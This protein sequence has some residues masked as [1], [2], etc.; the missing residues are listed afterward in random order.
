MDM[1]VIFPGGQ[2]VNALYKGFVIG[3]DQPIPNGGADSAPAPFDL[4]L[5]SIGT[6]A[7]FYVLSFCQRRGIPVDDMRLTLHAKEN[8]GTELIGS[9]EIE[10]QLPPEFPE[11]YRE[12]VRR[13]ATSCAV[14]KHIQ[15][16][17]TFE[18]YTR[19]K[20]GTKVAA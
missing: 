17:P 9:I 16:P 15:N 4:F 7:G 10:I 18:V 8:E 1:E 20:E 14:T 12:A 2:T 11:R 19:M 3:T 6:C 5:A 13:A